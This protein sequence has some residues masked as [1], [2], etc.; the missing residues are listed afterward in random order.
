MRVLSFLRGGGTL[1][2]LEQS[3]G[4][5]RVRSERHPGLVLLKYNQIKSPF[6]EPIVREC[7]GLILDETDGF[8]VVSRSFDKFF[9]H[10]E[11]GHAEI[12]WATAE[13]QEKLDGS[14]CVLYHHQGGW[15]VQTSGHPDASGPA[16]ASGMRFADLFWSVFRDHGYALPEPGHEDLC[17][18]FELMSPHNQVVVRHSAARLVLI[19]VR[20][21]RSGA[22]HPLSRAATL[23]ASARPYQVV[24][25]FG[26]GGIGDIAAS[27]ATMEPLQQEGYVVRDAS[28]RRV[29]VKHPGYVALHHLRDSLCPR[30]LVQAVQAGEIA[31]LSTYFPRLAGELDQLRGALDQLQA[32]LDAEYARLRDLP[33]QK[34]FALQAVKSRCPRALFAVRAGKSKSVRDF[35][36]EMPAPALM[37]LLGVRDEEPAAAADSA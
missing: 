18:A 37:Q 6:H 32:E 30:R 9:N 5:K 8:A 7:R 25:S 35:L 34:D 29:K 10:G 26:L 3:F 4:I 17:L 22:E 15:H 21:R 33:V 13:V 31:E 1:A 2:D 14:L 12:D 28:F 16:G 27:F 36:H 23:T 19:G 20:D 11:P 24:R